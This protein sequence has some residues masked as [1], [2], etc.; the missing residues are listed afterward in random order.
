MAVH[1]SMSD[2]VLTFSEPQPR[3]YIKMVCSPR[4][5]SPY[6]LSISLITESATWPAS[7]P[8]LAAG[9][10]A[11]NFRCVRCSSRH[12][13]AECAHLCT[14]RPRPPSSL[15]P[16]PIRTAAVLPDHAAASVRD[17]SPA[18]IR[19]VHQQ[20]ACRHYDGRHDPAGPAAAVTAQV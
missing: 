17:V 12:H 13:S 8:A 3:L 20:S 19:Y 4:L 11:S 14:L 18:G 6:S 10:V 9:M 2:P 15:L 7:L 5:R 1:E 16:R